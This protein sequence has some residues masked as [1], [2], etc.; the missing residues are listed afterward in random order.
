LPQNVSRLKKIVLSLIRLDTADKTK[1]SLRL[2]R[3]QAAWK[4][5]VRMRIPGFTSQ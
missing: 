5:D 3:K 4:D 2:T 1:T